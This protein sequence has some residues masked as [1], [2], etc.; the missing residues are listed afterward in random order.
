MEKT[1][2]P[3]SGYLALV[4]SLLLLGG[5]AYLFIY[6]INDGDN[7]DITYVII[8]IISFFI[9]CFLLILCIHLKKCLY[10]QKTCRDRL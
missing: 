4:I 2:K 7:P 6:G 3:M 8:S 9:T 1:L 5:S 10:V